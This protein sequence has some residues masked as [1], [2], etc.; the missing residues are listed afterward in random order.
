VVYGLYNAQER[1]FLFIA[2]HA[3]LRRHDRG[4]QPQGRGH[5]RKRLQEE[6]PDNIRAAGSDDALRL[7]PPRILSL[8]ESM[9]FLS[10]DELLG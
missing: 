1:G 3:R 6:A 10:E 8:E 5:R 2:P 7:T 4:R 9:E